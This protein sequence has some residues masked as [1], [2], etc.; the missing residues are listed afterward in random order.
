MNKILL[1][2]LLG[3]LT[4]PSA[5]QTAA[6]PVAV[7][8]PLAP[9]SSL[10]LD[11]HEGTAL[12]A[13][14]GYGAVL[15]PNSSLRREWYVLRDDKAPLALEGAVGVTVAQE[16]GALAYRASYRLHAREP[17][18]AFELRIHLLDVFGNL[19]RTLAVTELADVSEPQTFQAR[20]GLWP[21]H[22]A[23]EVF[24]TVAYVARVRTASAQVYE[25]PTAELL[26]QLRKVVRRVG[27]EDLE[28]R[29]EALAR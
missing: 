3:A 7:A 25:A 11:R 1:G 8:Y 20:W 28:P 18:T 17:V 27:E 12:R 5:A 13:D 14:I 24:A 10:R 23:T 15:H 29:R 6:A 2:A 26:A 4:L 21:V 16:D 9:A 19:I 22:E